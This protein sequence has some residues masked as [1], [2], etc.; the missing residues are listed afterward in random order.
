MISN[1]I[2]MFPVQLTDLIPEEGPPFPLFIHLHKN[3]RYVPVRLTND[4]LGTEKY[5]SF[6]KYGLREMWIP[7]G[8]RGR[9]EEYMNRSKAKDLEKQVEPALTEGTPPKVQLSQPNEDGI[10]EETEIVADVL[11][12]EELSQE[13]KAEILASLGQDLLRSFNQIS[14]KGEDGQQEAIK[15]GAQI[16]DEILAIASQNSNIYAEILALRQSKQ[17][18]EHSIMVST[19]AVMFGLA[20]GYSDEI[21]LADI[22]TAGLFHDIGLTKVDPNILA[23]PENSWSANERI[24]Y[25]GHVPAGIDILKSAN[26]NYNELV[27]NMISEHHENY[28]GSGFPEQKRGFEIAETSELVH[29]S[30]WFDRIASGKI[31]GEPLSPAESLDKIFQITTD[32]HSVKEVRPELVQ[33]IFEFMLEE[34]E[35]AENLFNE[36]ESRAKYLQNEVK[37]T[38]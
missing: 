18:I 5:E 29:L 3:E 19:L 13:A 33:R 25:Q 28:D 38:G 10:F 12:D 21:V 24:H 32:K 9:Y 30:N 6:L 7:E 31:N 8:F 34:K 26:A 4:P 27:Y 1:K 15:R 37:R 22:A 20:I 17:D 23:K 2:K 11:M 16:A 14:N 35:A 36:A